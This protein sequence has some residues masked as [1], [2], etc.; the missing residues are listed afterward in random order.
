MHPKHPRRSDA[1]LLEAI[2]R[3]PEERDRAMT[4]LYHDPTLRNMVFAALLKTMRDGQRAEEAFGEGLVQFMLSVVEGKFRGESTIR[5]YI[6]GICINLGKRAVA[7]PPTYSKREQSLPTENIEQIRPET[8]DSPENIF[9]AQESEGILGRLFQKLYRQLPAH[10]EKSLR[11]FYNEDRTVREIA[12]AEQ[13]QEQSV[14]NRLSECRKK[15]RE[16]IGQDPDAMKII[17]E[18]RWNNWKK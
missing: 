1:D 2:R 12:A 3:S 9:L 13:M 18:R 15:L 7:R 6:V 17:Q 16:L 14:K 11:W 4:G 8:S 10:C 5:T